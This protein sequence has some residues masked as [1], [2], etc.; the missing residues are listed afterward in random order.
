MA[1]I[2]EF[3][4]SIGV[5]TPMFSAAAPIYDAALAQGRGKQDTA[6]VCAVLQERV[7]RPR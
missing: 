2:G 5:E 3:A 4:E 1:L 6:A 7:R